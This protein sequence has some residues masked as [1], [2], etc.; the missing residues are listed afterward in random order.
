VRCLAAAIAVAVLGTGALV[1]QG[2]G[3]GGGDDGTAGEPGTGQLQITYI[4]EPGVK[5]RA[6]TLVCPATDADA[7]AACEEIESLGRPF[8]PVPADAACTFI[9]GGP[10]QIALYGTWEGERVNTKLTRTNGCEI[11]RYE[12]LAPVLLPLVGGYGGG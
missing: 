5:P 11:E 12:A 3:G 4:P 9:F 10:E 8:D 2:C 1:A 7:R 6:A